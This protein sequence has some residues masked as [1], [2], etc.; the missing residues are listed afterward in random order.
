VEQAAGQPSLLVAPASLLGNWAAEI[1]KFAPAMPL[2]AS[3]L[4]FCS[5]QPHR[6]NVRRVRQPDILRHAHI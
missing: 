2:G 4:L 1:E 6:P 5:S 3:T